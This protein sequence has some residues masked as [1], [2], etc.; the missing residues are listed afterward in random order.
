MNCWVYCAPLSS[1]A[2]LSRFLRAR[3]HT[4]RVS[5]ATLSLSAPARAFCMRASLSAKRNSAYKIAVMVE[6]ITKTLVLN[7]EVLKSPKIAEA[8]AKLGLETQLETVKAIGE[9][10]ITGDFDTNSPLGPTFRLGNI[11]FTVPWSCVRGI[12]GVHEDTGDS[13]KRDAQ[14]GTSS[15]PGGKSG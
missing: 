4:K 7:D 9:L 1:S 5:N 8:F 6:K 12:L 3:E 15:M 13:S 2:S 11:D 10:S 14:I